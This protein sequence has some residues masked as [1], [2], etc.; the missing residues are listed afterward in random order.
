MRQTLRFAKGASTRLSQWPRD[1][2]DGIYGFEEHGL[3]GTTMQRGTQFLSRPIAKITTNAKELVISMI[4]FGISLWLCE[5]I[6]SAEHASRYCV[7][8]ERMRQI[9]DVRASEHGSALPTRYLPP[10][11]RDSGLHTT[12]RRTNYSAKW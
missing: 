6:G 1:S 5:P 10:P 7:P 2:R 9:S 8:F 4:S 3:R 12:Y 11:T